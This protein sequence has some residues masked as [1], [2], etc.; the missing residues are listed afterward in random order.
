MS[1]LSRKEFKELLTEWKQINLSERM[2]AS[3]I[4]SLEKLNPGKENKALKITL[5]SVESQDKDESEAEGL[6]KRF[7]VFNNIPAK[8]SS[9]FKK[10]KGFKINGKEMSTSE[11]AVFKKDESNMSMLKKYFKKNNMLSDESISTLDSTP[12]NHHVLFMSTAG[13]FFSPQKNGVSLNNAVDKIAYQLHDA[14]HVIEFNNITKEQSEDFSNASLEKELRSLADYVVINKYISNKLSPD[15]ASYK[16]HTVGY[17]DTLAS[18]FAFL[19]TYVLKV[20]EDGLY[21]KVPS[22]IESNIDNLKSEIESF[23]EE[24]LEFANP[25]AFITFLKKYAKESVKV[26]NKLIALDKKLIFVFYLS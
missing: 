2:N 5:V 8:A 16:R 20:K 9:F 21:D 14:W 18:I 10:L 4:K 3:D 11:V 26:W 24:E 17:N 13:N 7:E 19:Q 22:N 23:N 1:K 15:D 25:D 12:D 6:S